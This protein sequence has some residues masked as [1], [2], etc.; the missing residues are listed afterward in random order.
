MWRQSRRLTGRIIDGN[1]T[2]HVLFKLPGEGVGAPGCQRRRVVF[3]LQGRRPETVAHRAAHCKLRGEG[4]AGRE[5]AAGG[6]AKVAVMLKT[7]GHAGIPLVG[8]AL[9]EVDVACGVGARI[10]MRIRRGKAG[11]ARCTG[12]GALACQRAADREHVAAVAIRSQFA[13][14][15]LEAF[16]TE[17]KA[18]RDV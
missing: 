7:P 18:G 10:V 2:G 5:L 11:Q 1:V 12:V 14:L 17:L 15:D 13:G 8:Q 6:V 16:A 4:I 3:L 9:A